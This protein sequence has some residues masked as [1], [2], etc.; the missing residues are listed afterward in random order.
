MPFNIELLILFKLCFC[1]H[2]LI[3]FDIMYLN[4]IKSYIHHIM[5][6]QLIIMLVLFFII[7]QHYNLHPALRLMWWWSLLLLFVWWYELVWIIFAC[8]WDKSPFILIIGEVAFVQLIRTLWQFSVSNWNC[9]PS[10]ILPTGF[11]N[12]YFLLP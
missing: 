3:F 10:L 8:R 6:R 2:I 4:I 1:F 5:T 7:W 9:Y 12:Y 11:M